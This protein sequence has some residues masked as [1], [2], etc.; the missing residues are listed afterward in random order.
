MGPTELIHIGFD[1][2]NNGFEPAD[3]GIFMFDS[4]ARTNVTSIQ[5]Q[6]EELLDNVSS[7]SHWYSNPFTIVYR[8]KY[9]EN[10]SERN[11]LV[12][13]YSTPDGIPPERNILI[14]AYLGLSKSGLECVPRFVSLTQSG[15][16]SFLIVELEP[17]ENMDVLFSRNMT[18]NALQSLAE[19]L[20]G[21]LQELHDAD[22]L[23]LD[24]RPENVLIQ[25]NV[26]VPVF[27]EVGAIWKRTED[28]GVLVTS[29]GFVAPELDAGSL[30]SRESDRWDAGASL[31]K[32]FC[33]AGAAPFD[34][35]DVLHSPGLR[36]SL[37]HSSKSY[38]VV[39]LSLTSREPTARPSNAEAK[40]ILCKAPAGNELVFSAVK[41]YLKRSDAW[42]AGPRTLI[43]WLEKGVF[44]IALACGIAAAV[45]G[46]LSKLEGTVLVSIT[47]LVIAVFYEIVRSG[48][49]KRLFNNRRAP[50]I[51]SLMKMVQ[52]S[53]TPPS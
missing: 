20:L 48:V 28:S 3:A 44:W 43:D 12:R 46:G 22:I 40:Q 32:G 41:A 33:S 52:R 35:Q 11:V 15:E 31:L 39:A 10:G 42:I 45:V 8:A 49:A 50:V 4:A 7:I 51:S 25:H 13:A 9:R 6:A 2:S 26:K 27:F 30:P 53:V 34:L 24:L 36:D 38:V 29:N 18:E 21:S 5:D 16:L 23:H 1:T 37:M 14:K 19:D 17:G 47:F